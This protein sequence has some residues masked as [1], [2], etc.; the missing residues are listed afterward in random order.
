MSFKKLRRILGTFAIAGLCAI[1]PALSGCN[2]GHPEAEIAVTFN[3]MNYVLKYKLYRTMY[4]QTVQHFIELADNGFY[5]N[6]FVHNYTSSTWYAGAYDYVVDSSESEDSAYTVAYGEGKEGFREYLENTSKDR[7]YEE[8][9]DPAK[10]KITPTVYKDYIGGK[11]TGPLNT[12]IGEF[13]NNQHKIENGALKSSFGCLRM[14]YSSKTNIDTAKNVQVYLKK[15]GSP[16]GVKGSYNYNSATSIFSIQQNRTTT[17]DSNYC[18]FGVLQNEQALTDLR[19]AVSSYSAKIGST[20]FSLDVNL[21]VDNRDEYVGVN[22]N[23]VSYR[24]TSEPIV[25]KYVKITK[26]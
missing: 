4:P 18:I 13:S 15:E 26:Y 2:T 5:N 24:V 22:M 19:S 12:L 11:L 21:Y 6:T 14:Y 16:L 17:T 1:V 25:I 8:L 10:G 3:G 23:E 9:A 20:K 7:E